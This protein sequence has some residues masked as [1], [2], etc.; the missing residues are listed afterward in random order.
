MKKAIWVLL[1]LASPGS[2]AAATYHLSSANT[3]VAFSVQRLGIPWVTA[4]FSDIAGEFVLDPQGATSHVSVTVGI[5]SLDCNE[6]RWNDRL[7]S[8]EWL[9]AARYPRMTYQSNRI[10]LDH[11]HATATG[12][13]TLHGV[14][15]PVILNVSYSDCNDGDICR[16]SARGRI[17]RSQYGLPHSFWTGGDP[18]EILISGQIQSDA[19]Q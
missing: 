3:Q 11:G 7:R 19:H 14:T 17:K 18:V 5:A 12:L 2:E 9:D 1:F 6:S 4:R 15:L 16:F 13:L 10:E 8:A